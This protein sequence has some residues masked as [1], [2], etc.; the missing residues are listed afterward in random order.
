M[1][2]LKSISDEILALE[3]GAVLANGEPDEVLEDP[4]LVAA[5]L[6][7]N[8]AVVERSGATTAAPAAIAVE[9][10]PTEQ[11]WASEG[12][13]QGQAIPANGNKAPIRKAPA[14]KRPLSAKKAPP[15]KR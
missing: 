2:L 8:Q 4:R 9:D 15:R 12:Q 13:A 3:T 7:T 10:E 1:P 5:Y 11:V 14:R 6:G